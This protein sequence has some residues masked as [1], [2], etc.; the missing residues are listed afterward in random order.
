MA[1]QPTTHLLEVGPDDHVRI[2]NTQAQ[3]Q[4]GSDRHSGVDGFSRGC[5][6]SQVEGQGRVVQ[7]KEFRSI[8][9]AVGYEQDQLWHR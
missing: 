9:A 5:K 6:G 3:Q 1:G 8:R 4:E 7:I 2:V